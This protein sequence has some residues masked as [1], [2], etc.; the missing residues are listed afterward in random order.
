MPFKSKAQKR[1]M[2]ANH[3]KMA[4]KWQKH[5][6]KGT[7]LPEKVS[8]A[9]DQGISTIDHSTINHNFGGNLSIIVGN[10]VK[11]RSPKVAPR[12]IGSP[13]KLDPTRTITLRRRFITDLRRRFARLQRV[14]TAL[15]VTEDAFGLRQVEHD[16]FANNKEL[17]NGRFVGCDRAGVPENIQNAHHLRRD[18]GLNQHY[19]ERSSNSLQSEARN[20]GGTDVPVELPL[21]INTRFRFHTTAGQIAAFRKWLASQIHYILFGSTTEQ[22]EEGFWDQYIREGYLK[23]A[24]RAFD[25]VRKP[26]LADTAEKLD[27]YKGTKQEFLRS[28]FGTPVAVEKVK[29][30]AGRTYNDLKG[31]TDAMSAKMQ[32]ELTDGLVQGQ[33]PR[34]IARTLNKTVDTLGKPRASTIARTEIVRAH[35]EG[36]LDAMQNLGV[37]EVGVMV[38]WSTSGL[39]ITALGNPSPCELCADLQGLVIALDE[40][41]G[42]LPRHP[43]CMCSFVP[44]NVGESTKGQIRGKAAIEKAIDASIQAE[45]PKRPLSEQKERTSWQGADR[46]IDKTRPVPSVKP[47]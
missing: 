15:V 38:E 10:V 29:L 45:S 8:N 25:D 27:F 28:S 34:E 9:G 19:H 1:W 33:S 7:N 3:P 2:Y 36:S 5:T 12:S 30:L 42:M 6:R 39:G 4:R 32:R 22:I 24:G 11:R 13:L 31:V 40:A 35:A 26:A 47:K 18:T 21:H 43:N 16:P 20:Q 37:E 46:T 44:A 41:R 23:G 17:D 14:I